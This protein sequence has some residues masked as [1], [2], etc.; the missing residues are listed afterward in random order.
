MIMRR[1]C[2]GAPCLG[3]S[4]ACQRTDTSRVYI[5]IMEKKLETTIMGSTIMGYIG[6]VGYIW[7]YIGTMEKKMETLCTLPQTKTRA[8][9]SANLF[10]CLRVSCM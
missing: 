2:K 7:G 4:V 8:P 3:C 1:D 6:I 9:L 10:A 5:G